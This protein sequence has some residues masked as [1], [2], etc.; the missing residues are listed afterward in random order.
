MKLI[1]SV[2]YITPEWLTHILCRS[3]YLSQGHVVSVAAQGQR[4]NAAE[5]PG[6][7]SRNRIEIHYSSDATPSAP[8]RLYLK[9]HDGALH[10]S[11][12]EREVVFYRSVAAQMPAPPAPICFDAAY[13]AETGAY[14][15]LLEDVSQTHRT[16]HPEEPATRNDTDRMLDALAKLHAHWWGH[17]QLGLSIGSLPSPEAIRADFAQL[18][19][20]F[21]T[22]VDYLGD[23]LSAERRRIY[24]RV[25]EQY[26]AVFIRRL[27]QRETL[28][29][30][31]N[32]AHAGNF[33]LPRQAAEQQVYLID[34]Q[35]WDVHVGLRDVAY[36][37]ALFWYPERRARMEQ[38]V[39]K[40]YHDRLRQYGVE[41]YDWQACWDDYR[42]QAI[43]N[44]FV[45][46]WAW[47]FEGAHWGFHR[48]HQLE[49][50]MMA[51]EDLKCEEFLA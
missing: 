35:Q 34:W 9:A 19:N 14:H 10:K 2:D 5:G 15:L 27:A 29:L 49:K 16:V 36:L 40:G 18:G 46:F 39:V 37:I 6:F 33:L 50:A 45:P 23:R 7:D 1:S 38:I 30:V 43:E 28:T 31:H 17:P 22:Y 47:V 41:G 32:D 51:F 21:P 3:G 42:F 20:V 12:G 13:D 25:L 26:P 48:W 24:E 4:S 11:A 44:M 8:T